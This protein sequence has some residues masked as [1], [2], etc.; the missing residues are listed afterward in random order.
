[1]ARPLR[2]RLR[3]PFTGA[4]ALR[5]PAFRAL[6][7]AQI[8]SGVGTWS[9]NLA[10]S[11]LVLHLTGSAAAL[12]MVTAIQFAPVL[13]LSPVTGR[14]LDRFDVRHVLLATGVA[15]GTTA[16]VLAVLAATGHAPLWAVMIAVGLFGVA[17][18]F[19]RPGAYTLLPRTVDA[20][21]R[22]SAIGLVT[23]SNAVARLGGP[24]LAGLLYATVGPAACF[25]FNGLSYGAV[26][27]AL[28]G[29]PRLR[30]TAPSPAD[31]G[32]ADAGPVEAVPAE[33]ARADAGSTAPAPAPAPAAPAP[34]DAALADAGHPDPPARRRR[35][36]GAPH[37]AS[38]PA[39]TGGLGLRYAWRHPDLRAALLANAAIGCLTFNFAVMLAAMVTFTF[40]AGS[41]TVGLAY[42]TDAVGAVLG[43][44]LG[45]GAAVTRRRTAATC[46]ALGLTV[47]VAALA[48]NLPLFLA[49]L[50]VMGVMITRYQSTVTALVQQRSDP[51]LL[52][53]MMTLLT[54]GW[55]GT[56]P[57]GALLIGWI[58]DA[59][60]PRAAMGVAA[61]TCLV[62]AAALLAPRRP[63]PAD[64]S[65]LGVGQ[66]VVGEPGVGEEPG[67]TR[68]QGVTRKQGAG[69][70]QGAPAGSAGAP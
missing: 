42:S 34:A 50:P 53:R 56:T 10:T 39:S 14:V 67:V 15:G 11:L 27:G 17:G 24:A 52:G 20:E 49:A 43:G 46:A 63:R 1:M 62:C 21:R 68:A 30:T 23:A 58:A 33:A 57:V 12:G 37:P 54:L 13:V 41:G 69:G 19:D 7:A 48:P 66:R 29:L 70:Q 40:D 64:G 22:A 65:P 26:I 44:L 16:L 32:L 55:F 8:V 47:G 45:V 61:S 25:A 51:A 5:I 4:Q 60:S 9:Q 28:V 31:T 36:A 6:F 59:Y 3:S 35:S 2:R 38:A 18:A